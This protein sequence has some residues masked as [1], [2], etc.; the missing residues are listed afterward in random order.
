MSQRLNKYLAHSL[1]ISRRTADEIIA[2]GQIVVN[3]KTAEIGQKV[4]SGDTVLYRGKPVKSLE[5]STLIMLNKPVGYVCS[6]AVQGDSKTVYDLLPEQ[7]RKLKTVGRLDKN[8]SGLILLT[9]DGD[10]SHRMTHPSFHKN[11]TYLVTLDKPLEPLHQQM[12]SDFGIQLED[13]PSQLTLERL[14]DSRQ[15]WRISMHEGRNRQIRRTFQALDYNVKKLHRTQF[16]PY[17]L[18]SLK[19]GQYKPLDI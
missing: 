8:S 16:G 2:S 15:C 18:D 1:G 11:K 3:A 5:Q 4:E 19:T 17:S 13:G 9:D 14:D 7:Y 12:I 6:R 10:F